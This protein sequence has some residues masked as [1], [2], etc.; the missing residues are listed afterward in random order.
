[1]SEAAAPTSGLQSLEVKRRHILPKALVVGLVAGLIASG[2]RMALQYCELSRIA[3]IQ[4]LPPVEG[5]AVALGVGALGSGLGLW[6]VRRFAPETAGS[7][8]PDLK[9]VVLGERQL[10]WRRVLPIK[11]L[12]GV[13]GIG[14]GLTL[15]R[16]GPTVQMGGATG[17][18]VSTWFRVKRGE[19]ER[20]ALISAGAAAGLAAA[21]N[22]PLAGLI[23]VL[24]ELNGNFTPVVFVAS[25]LA[26]VTADVVC[27]IVTGETPVFALHGMPGPSLHALPVA[28]LLGVLAGFAGVAFNKSILLSLDLFE[29][30]KKWPPFAVGAC[31]GLV[32]GL[33]AWIYPGMS[34]SGAVLTERSLSGGIAVKW[35]VV[36]LA[37]RFVLT[38]VSY[39]CGAA[40]G[41]FAPLLVLGSLGG[42]ALGA[43]VHA[44]L[45][46]WAVFPETFAVIGMGALF[47]STVRAPLTAIVLMTELTGKYDFMLPL[48]VACFAAYGIA[49]GLGDKPI[50]EALRE[51]AASGRAERG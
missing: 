32:V 35:M 38:M 11:F 42:L 45:P 27:R 26:A 8:I 37:A 9:A 3:W 33:A 46:E 23:F 2:F 47:T 28:A 49:E 36:L 34:G 31:A 13:L 22:A 20:K 50:Y 10:H 51:R 21:F 29:R 7:G 4:R 30:L 18:M 39:G 48:L 40:G 1:M 12:A 44:F 15:G 6:L 43:G 16:E 17:I 19:G 5:L 41:I 25:F 24:E 14:G